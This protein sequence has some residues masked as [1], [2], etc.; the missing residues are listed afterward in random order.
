MQ[1]LMITVMAML[2]VIAPIVLGKVRR[3]L[4]TPRLLKLFQHMLWTTSPRPATALD[5]GADHADAHQFAGT[6]EWENLLA[7]A[8]SGRTFC[9]A[10]ACRLFP[11]QIIAA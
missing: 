5:T 9:I 11:K 1:Q 7:Y 6:P 4:M 2:S 8:R 10:F 3:M